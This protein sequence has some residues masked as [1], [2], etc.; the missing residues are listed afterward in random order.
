MIYPIAMWFL[1]S[2]PVPVPCQ[3]V[4][5]AILNTDT[6]R[7]LRLSREVWNPSQ[8]PKPKT[9]LNPKPL[10]PKPLEH[11]KLEAPDRKPLRTYMPLLLKAAYY[12]SL[13]NYVYCFGV[14]YNI[15]LYTPKPYSKS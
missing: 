3:V 12:S 14:H 4:I 9:F 1:R 10:S 8:D 7:I 6:A 11:R 5:A 15:I 2:C 13:S